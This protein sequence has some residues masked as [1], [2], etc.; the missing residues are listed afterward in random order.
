M[1]KTRLEKWGL[2]RNLKR[3][4][5]S[6]ILGGH[7]DSVGS[8]SKRLAGSTDIDTQKLRRNLRRH[9]ELLAAAS[10][11]IRAALNL[12]GRTPSNQQPGIGMCSTGWNRDTEL[13]LV[14][15]RN[16]HRAHLTDGTWTWDQERCWNATRG[17]EAYRTVWSI[18]ND[19]TLAIRCMKASRKPA[20]G[21]FN[22]AFAGIH[23]AIIDQHPDFTSCILTTLSRLWRHGH[24]EIARML[25]SHIYAFSRLIF[26]S[27]SHPFVMVWRL[28]STTVEAARWEIVE[29]ATAAVWTEVASTVGM[30]SAFSL[31]FLCDVDLALDNFKCPKDR[32]LQLER[33]LD[34]VGGIASLTQDTW[35]TMRSVVFFRREYAV[36]LARANKDAGNFE[37]AQRVLTQVLDDDAAALDWGDRACLVYWLGDVKRGAGDLYGAERS[38]REAL[39]LIQPYDDARAR[40]WLLQV[41][42]DLETLLLQME[43]SPEAQVVRKRL[44]DKVGK[45][46]EDAR[47]EFGLTETPRIT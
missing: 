2:V 14:A 35:V 5:I 26:K 37:G 13:L 41:L 15:I 7:C 25:Y 23:R 16:Y 19:I 42:S 28:I 36:V 47:L 22:R 39:F 44:L 43:R 6:A 30:R 33:R 40:R 17:R 3:S 4:V 32:L 27:P 21:I 18:G 20:P 34:A 10:P 38:Y 8:M 11:E 29:R 9:P 31:F 1:Y 12:I 46:E 24:A 45:L